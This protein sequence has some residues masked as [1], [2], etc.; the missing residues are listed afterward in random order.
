VLEVDASIR[1][2]WILETC[3]NTK[4]RI[5]AV[6]EAKKMT[7]TNIEELKKLGY[8][9]N[10]S[11]GIITALEKYEN[12]DLNKYV[13]LIHESLQYLIPGKK[14]LPDIKSDKKNDEEP[15]VEKTLEEVEEKE[16][17]TP[18]PEEDKQDN[19]QET[20]DIVFDAI[21]NLEGED[22][23]AWDS[24]TDKCEKT[25]LDRDSIEE[26]LSSLMDK[27]L[28]YEPVLGTIKTT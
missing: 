14:E 7:E 6:L 22:G 4:D 26:A 24:I 10:L 2:R 21:K 8:S 28:I 18:E 23:A 1:D 15:V 11:E 5:E 19:A 27:G 17:K 16:K 9:K 12:I 13:T 3:Q 25:G 20:E